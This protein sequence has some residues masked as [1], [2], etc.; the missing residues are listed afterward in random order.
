MEGAIPSSAGGFPTPEI[1]RSLTQ[2]KPR[3]PQLFSLNRLSRSVRAFRKPHTCKGSPFVR[4]GKLDPV[5]EAP[6]L[7]GFTVPAGEAFFS[8]PVDGLHRFSPASADETQPSVGSP[9]RKD[10]PLIEQEKNVSKSE[11]PHPQRFTPI[12]VA[13]RRFIVEARTRRDSSSVSRGNLLKRQKAPHPQGLLP[14]LFPRRRAAGS[15]TPAGVPL[16]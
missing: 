1:Y 6:H 13:R 7:Q 8:F 15:S 10:S 2:R 4:I 16:E 14:P 12:V 3:N 9:T 11:A 5:W